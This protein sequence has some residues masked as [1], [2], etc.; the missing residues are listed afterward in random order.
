M[1]TQPPGDSLQPFIELAQS[2]RD[3]A[4]NRDYTELGRLITDNLDPDLATVMLYVTTPIGHLTIV[5]SY[6]QHWSPLTPDELNREP[7]LTDMALV[8]RAARR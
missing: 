7:N 4:A 2:L 3:A 6:I 8:L 5:G 1:S